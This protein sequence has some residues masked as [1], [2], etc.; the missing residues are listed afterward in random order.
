MKQHFK[1]IFVKIIRLSNGMKVNQV[2]SYVWYFYICSKQNKK[3]LGFFV[4]KYYS[5]LLVQTAK[6]WFCST[7][8]CIPP[9][10]VHSLLVKGLY[11]RSW[12]HKGLYFKLLFKFL[13][14]LNEMQRLQFSGPERLSMFFLTPQVPYFKCQL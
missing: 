7:S 1:Y 4:R 12:T 13:F 3:N 14:F 10:A 2:C 9:L 8:T 11:Q 6:G 5:F